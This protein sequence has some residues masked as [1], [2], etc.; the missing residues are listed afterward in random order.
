MLSNHMVICMCKIRHPQVIKGLQDY[1]LLSFY[2]ESKYFIIWTK[3]IFFQ[4]IF[5][6][7]W[8]LVV[9]LRTFPAMSAGSLVV[10]CE[11]FSCGT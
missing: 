10:A 5:W 11:I 1:L 9:T 8:V 4:F 3:N 7:C 2:V 6:L